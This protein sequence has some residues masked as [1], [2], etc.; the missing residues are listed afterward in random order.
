M[1]DF[2][3]K[4]EA[5]SK[6]SYLEEN[7][8]Y[9]KHIEVGLKQID[10]LSNILLPYEINVKA[11]SWYKNIV[12]L[13]LKDAYKFYEDC[14]RN[15]INI[16]K[17]N[18]IWIRKNFKSFMSEV[19]KFTKFFVKSCSEENANDFCKAIDSIKKVVNSNIDI[20][21]CDI[22][23]NET[24][25][26]IC[27]QLHHWRQ[28][29]NKNKHE[30]DHMDNVYY[31]NNNKDTLNIVGASVLEYVSDSIYQIIMPL[32]FILVQIKERQDK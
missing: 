24:I 25:E 17:S 27:N 16:A 23:M 30:S 32:L 13:H 15:D 6:K 7:D 19:E 31:F 22:Q 10:K 8:E 2:I 20:F 26:C 4:F 14:K 12:E 28:V 21:P 18:D 1:E 29:Y 3:D 11:Q 9:V 5:I